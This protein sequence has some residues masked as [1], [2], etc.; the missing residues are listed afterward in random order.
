[1][2][3]E[4]IEWG[5][6][7]RGQLSQLLEREMREESRWRQAGTCGGGEKRREQ[8]VDDIGRRLR[9]KARKHNR[10]PV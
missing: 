8:F 3:C 10:R 4:I 7:D 2:E 9:V 6:T 5:T 1:M